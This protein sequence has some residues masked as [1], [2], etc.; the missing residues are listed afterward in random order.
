[1]TTHADF[2]DNAAEK[3]AKSKISDLDG[4]HSTL[5]RTQNYLS[6][7]DSV[8]EIGCGTGA[9]AL[10]LAPYV[11]HIVA[12]DIS[13]KMVSIGA[14]NAQAEGI[15]N[16]NFVA[17]DIFGEKI[18]G[19]TYDAILAHNVLHLLEDVPSSVRRVHE[20]LRPGGIFISKT[21][22]VKDEGLSF[23]MRM[24]KLV[25][26]LMQKLGKAPFVNFMKGTQLEEAISENGF[27]ILESGHYP[28]TAD[29]RYIVARKR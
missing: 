3:Y 21:F 27:D 15:K 17:S 19:M 13:P 2:W 8:L 11:S 16:I 7:S 26:P 18:E 28:I 4:Y 22:A 1:M 14:K 6:K 25:L 9:T 29:A 5:T 12:S 23:K 10:L 24:I 20:L